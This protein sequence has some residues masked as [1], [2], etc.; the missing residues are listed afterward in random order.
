MNLKK[1]IIDLKKYLD[2]TKYEDYEMYRFNRCD[3]LN[4]YIAI[5]CNE[6]NKKYI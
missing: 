6:I 1:I 5:I 2:F 3:I 4:G